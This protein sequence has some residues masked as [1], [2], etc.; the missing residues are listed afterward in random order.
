MACAPKI[1]KMAEPLA[2]TFLFLVDCGKIDLRV[3]LAKFYNV[4][5]ILSAICDYEMVAL[6]PSP[7]FKALDFCLKCLLSLVDFTYLL[8]DMFHHL[9]VQIF[10]FLFAI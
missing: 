10:L 1:A 3:T 6:T 5:R 7:P 2:V 4:I 8:N 9:L